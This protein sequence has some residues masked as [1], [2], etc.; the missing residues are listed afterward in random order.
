MPGYRYA[1]VQIIKSKWHKKKTKTQ[2]QQQKKE[3]N[4]KQTNTF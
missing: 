3:S 2:Q 4:K 1:I